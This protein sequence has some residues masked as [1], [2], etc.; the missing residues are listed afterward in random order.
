MSAQYNVVWNIILVNERRDDY[1]FYHSFEPSHRAAFN[2]NFSTFFIF[3][4]EIFHSKHEPKY[5]LLNLSVSITIFMVV[6]YDVGQ[7]F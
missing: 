5:R 1:S 7:M 4:T 2:V 3:Y 6:T